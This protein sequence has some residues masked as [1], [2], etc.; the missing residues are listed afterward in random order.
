[1]RIP[2]ALRHEGERFKGTTFVVNAHGALVGAHR[3]IPLGD[4]F[5]VENV[6]NRV[7]CH[8]RVVYHGGLAADG[9]FRLG[10]EMLEAHP[11]LWG[12]DYSLAVP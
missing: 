7:F 4:R 5:E 10:V 2:I 3:N 9:F 12:G 11:G 1:V 6:R 8:F